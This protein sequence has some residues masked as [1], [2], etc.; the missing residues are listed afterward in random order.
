MNKVAIPAMLVA[1]VMVAGIFAFLPVEQASTVHT[2]GTL[3]LSQNSNIDAILLDTATSIPAEHA[4]LPATSEVTDIGAASPTTLT[5]PGTLLASGTAGVAYVEC[6]QYTLDTAA[7]TLTV[8]GRT[9]DTVQEKYWIIA[10]SSSDAIAWVRN[11]ISDHATC[12]AF[13]VD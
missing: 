3:V 10:V 11:A 2:S 4:A 5:S 6:S 13:L 12:T 1:T 7:D 9:F 8:G